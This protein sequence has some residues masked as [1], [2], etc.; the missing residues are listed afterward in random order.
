MGKLFPDQPIFELYGFTAKKV[1][2]LIAEGKTFRFE[3]D[4]VEGRTVIKV[5]VEDKNAKN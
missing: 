4:S 5:Y 2:Q 3:V 1:A